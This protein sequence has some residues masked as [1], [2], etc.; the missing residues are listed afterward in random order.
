VQDP[1]TTDPLVQ[2]PL[3][4]D[5]LN[6]EPGIQETI[7]EEQVYQE[8]LNQ[9]PRTQEPIIEEQL[10]EESISDSISEEKN[11]EPVVKAIVD[12]FEND[13]LYLDKLFWE[14]DPTDIF[15][16]EEDTGIERLF[17]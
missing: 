10:V 7:I 14:Q 1:V 4:K 17:S 12:V 8:P 15:K 5:H 16:M 11:N 13:S 9:E 3:N 6:K 2:E